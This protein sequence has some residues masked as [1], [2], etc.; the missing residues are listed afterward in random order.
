[1][2]YP[3]WQSALDSMC[4][5]FSLINADKLI[6]K[7]TEE[8]SQTLF[9]QIIEYLARK[10]QLKSSIIEGTNHR[11]LMMILN[12]VVGDRIPIKITNRKNVNKLSCWWD[13]TREYLGQDN[14]AVVISLDGRESHFSTIKSMTDRAMALSDSGGIK[15]IRKSA[16]RLRGYKKEDKYVIYPSQ[17]IYLGK[18]MLK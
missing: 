14:R 12:D 3:Y 2:D 15:I 18:E 16:C 13:F 4:G 5:I 9:N 1:L 10:R 11:Q 7:S 6:N 8:E 17:C